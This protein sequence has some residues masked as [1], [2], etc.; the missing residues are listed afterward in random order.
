M[1]RSNQISNLLLA[2][3]IGLGGIAIF[4]ACTP[5]DTEQITAEPGI[6]DAPSTADQPATPAPAQ[7]EIN[8]VVEELTNAGSFETLTWAIEA[9]GLRDTLSE[10]ATYTVFAPTDAAIDALPQ[11]VQQKLLEPE[12]RDALTELIAYHIVSQPIS[13]DV[14]PSDELET[15]ARHPIN[16]EVENQQLQVNDVA[17]TQP[18]IE[19]DNG[20]IYPIDQVLLPPEFLERW[21]L[22]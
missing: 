12:Y 3:A 5:D 17:V 4:S 2:G 20:M 19:A 1:K 13:T 10:P 15:V 22:G 9:T 21:N 14:V 7:Y 11:E 18:G 8:T 6:V 16:V